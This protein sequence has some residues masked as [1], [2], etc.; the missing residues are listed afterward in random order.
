MNNLN[1]NNFN[2]NNFNIDNFNLDTTMYSLTELENLLNL[3]NPYT[4]NNLSD[5]RDILRNKI[6]VMSSLDNVKRE[7]IIIFLNNIHDRLL[8]NLN[9]QNIY[10]SGLS[11]RSNRDNRT[12]D[13]TH[14]DTNNGKLVDTNN[15]PPGYLNPINIK[16][17]KKAINIDS[18]FRTDY[19][20][21]KSTNY[22]ITLPERIN[23]IVSM[24]I[25]SIQIPLTYHAISPELKNN[26]FT[27]KYTDSSMA[28]IE[29]PAGNYETQF[30]KSLRAADIEAAINYQLQNCGIQEISNNIGFTVDRISGR[31]VFAPLL[32]ASNTNINDLITVQFNMND[33]ST[34]LIFKLGWQLGFRAAEYTGKSI[35]SEG[36]CYISGPRYIF[37]AINDFQTT[38]NNYF[39]AT[40]NESI[41]APN[42]IGRINIGSIAENQTIYK[43]GQDDDFGDS[44]NRTREYFGPTDIHR[45]AITL[46]DEYGRIIDLNYMDW[47]MV[48]SFECLYD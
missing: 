3:N 25:S 47:S 8:D 35:V 18:L 48:L 1:M 14:L 26:S 39:S 24:R 20:N 7:N 38:A 22:T 37:L 9:S 46:Y 12:S 4:S 21:S 2:M 13:T 10:Y 43:S 6:S 16:T 44:L 15:Y 23:K 19:Y 5:K 32:D 40:Y 45:L 11:N 36:I 33:D 17:I 27:I 30:S 29:L 34:P 42:I 31:S 41:L 28:T